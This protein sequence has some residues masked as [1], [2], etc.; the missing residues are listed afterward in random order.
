MREGYRLWNENRLAEAMERFWDPKAVLYHPPGWPEPGPSIGHAAVSA[1]F[2]R[3]RE[4]FDADRLEILELIEVEDRVVVRIRW[5][6]RGRGSGVDTT[7]D[8]S[9]VY[10]FS[11]GLIVR[12]A[13]FWDHDA[14]LSAAEE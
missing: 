13:F 8:M 6:V 14:A 4:D 11:D 3:V 2:E 9:G 1:Q 5:F 7:L 12:N 10:W